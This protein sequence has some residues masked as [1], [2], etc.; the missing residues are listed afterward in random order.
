MKGRSCTR[1][2]K[3]YILGSP[4]IRH[5]FLDRTGKAANK[6]R[7]EP[8]NLPMSKHGSPLPVSGKD[9]GT[10]DYKMYIVHIEIRRAIALL[11]TLP[12][13]LSASAQSR[14]TTLERRIDEV[15][16]TAVRAERSSMLGAVVWDAGAVMSPVLLLASSA[17]TTRL[18]CRVGRVCGRGADRS[19]GGAIGAGGCRP[20]PPPQRREGSRATTTDF[21]AS[22]MTKGASPAARVVFQA[23]PVATLSH[24]RPGT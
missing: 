1:S 20:R 19:A 12:I 24:I 3:F 18:G 10:D 14:D 16:V 13:A 9:K 17:R 8:E 22:P 4:H 6:R 15:T 23:I 5:W 7:N 21:R 11:F 2:R